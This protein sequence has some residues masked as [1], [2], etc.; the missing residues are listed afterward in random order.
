MTEGNLS[1]VVYCHRSSVWAVK[2]KF[3]RGLCARSTL[4][5]GRCANVERFN[6]LRNRHNTNTKSG[7]THVRFVEAGLW[8]RRYSSRVSEAL[9]WEFSEDFRELGKSV[10]KL[11]VNG[12]EQFQ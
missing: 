1:S 7:R 10:V 3:R 12:D 5:D 11:V 2:R 8:P 9:V 6:L 4:A